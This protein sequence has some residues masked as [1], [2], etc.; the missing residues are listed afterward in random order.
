MTLALLSPRLV[1]RF[2][3]AGVVVAS[4][5][6]PCAAR[7]QSSPQ[8]QAVAQSLYDEAKK[9]MAATK[10]SDACPKLE[11][12]QRLDPTPVTEF[13][14][15]D[16]YERAGRTA[17]AW[18]T[19][20]DLAAKEHA[21]GGAKSAEREKVA[22]DRARALEPKLSQLVVDVPAAVR[23][24]G[25]VVKRDGE[26]V[27]DGQWGAPVAV[28]PGKHTIE[29][30]APGKKAWSATQDVQGAGTTATV[31]VEVLADAPVEA[32]PAAVATAPATSLRSTPPADASSGSSPLRTVGLVVGG[33]GVAG[34]AVGT[35]FGVIALS[36][37]SAANGGNC[38]GSLGGPN[39]C[40]PTGVS[41]RQSAVT[42]G[43]VSTVAL[44]AGGVLLAGGAT[45][46][47]VAPSSHVQ[48]GAT[49]GGVLLR[50]D[51]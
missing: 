8:D 12:S 46:F 19:F 35:V 28:D 30:S 31:H 17:S 44:I 20:L 24:P 45:L 14:L 34:L 38:G 48:V 5:A 15:A 39:D 13:Y 2:L 10:W 51:F 25:L 36:K 47:L 27:R 1:R 40:N 26:A 32:P 33:V 29:A 23:V 50:G 21:T 22:R 16:C 42:A 43:N 49:A 11:E 9:L 41:D 7:A 37:N 6:T 18:T 3:A 4:L